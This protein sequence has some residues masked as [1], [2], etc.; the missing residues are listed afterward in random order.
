ME[1]RKLVQVYRPEGHLGFLGSGHIARP[2]I[3]RTFPESDPFIMLM[4]DMLDKKD[5]TPAGGPHPHAGFE[6]VTLI[7]EGELGVGEHKMCTGD[8]QLMTAGSGIVHTE[9]IDKPTKIRILQLWLT[10]SK[11]D[12]W[13]SPRVQDIALANVPQSEANGTRIRLYSGSLAGLTSPVLNHVPFILADIAVDAYTNTT[14]QLPANY[15]GFMY[16]L[17]GALNVG[18]NAQEL[19][20]DEVGWLNYPGTDG[21]SELTLSTGAQPARFVLYAGQPTGDPIYSYG[22]FIGNTQQDIPRLYHEYH[23][24]K[25]GHINE[26]GEERKMVW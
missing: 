25:M 14:L 23:Q 5:T 20:H 7:L 3:Q 2:V 1:Q 17:Q 11:A 19:R 10:L 12:R 13:A 6:T 21:L 16:M 26:V 22:P 24:G 9:I 8:M 18:P 15:N 4:D